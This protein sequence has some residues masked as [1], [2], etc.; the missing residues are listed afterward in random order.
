MQLEQAFKEANEEA[1]HL[2]LRTIHTDLR[3]RAAG[4]LFS[5][6]Q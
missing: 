6:A 1:S 5:I 3:S 4:A 2:A